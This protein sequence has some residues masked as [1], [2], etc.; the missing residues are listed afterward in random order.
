MEAH[1]LEHTEIYYTLHICTIV[2]LFLLGVPSLLPLRSQEF[3]CFLPTKAPHKWSLRYTLLS[4]NLTASIKC[5][6]NKHLI[7]SFMYAWMCVCLCVCRFFYQ[8]S[9]FHAQW[10]MS[11]HQ[12]NCETQQHRSSDA[13]NTHFCNKIAY[14][15]CQFVWVCALICIFTVN[16]DFVHINQWW[17]V[18]R[19]SFKSKWNSI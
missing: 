2:S 15:L 10:A 4:P 14:S 16:N 9:Q 7:R 8:N 13:S 1:I 6:L 5:V 17:Y 19:C 12:S 11:P 3:F 18:I